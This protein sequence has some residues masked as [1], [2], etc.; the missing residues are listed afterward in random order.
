MPRRAAPPWALLTAAVL[1]A[2]TLSA[3]GSDGTAPAKVASIR[4][5]VDSVRLWVGDSMQLSA[6]AL[7]SAGAT[8]ASTV[9]WES[10]TDAVTVTPR[11]VVKALRR[12]EGVIRARA[13]DA[14]AEVAIVALPAIRGRVVTPAGTH[15]GALW[16]HWRAGEAHDSAAVQGDGTFVIRPDS[17]P[18]A[19]ELLVDALEPR[20]YHPSLFPFSVDSAAGITIVLVPRTWTIRKGIY[21]GETVPTPLDLV[22]DDGNTGPAY[23]N[24]RGGGDRMLGYLASWADELFPVKVAL[25]RRSS[26]LEITAADS[27][28]LWT[29]WNRME[30]VFGVDLF[31]PVEADPTWAPRSGS[32]APPAVRRVIRVTKEPTIIGMAMVQGTAEPRVWSRE[33]GAWA[34]GGRWSAFELTRLDADAGWFAFGPGPEPPVGYG[35]VFSHEMLHVLG[36]GHTSRIPSPQGP[37][38]RTQEPS[39]YDVAYIEMLRA[40]MRLELQ[41]DTPYGVIPATIGERRIMLGLPA[42]PTMQPR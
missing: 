18:D 19:G 29:V 4:P 22:M 5:S 7:D 3:C 30:Q 20:H 35:V 16:A 33:L 37:A 15:H 9:R 42:L 23:F 1:A 14:V 27:T 21:Q 41:H 11:G 34:A 31:Q 32:E 2:L 26:P 6:V 24:T 13:G 12:G 25:D 38:M 10:A 39:R 8:I 40:V 17:T 36:V 28:R